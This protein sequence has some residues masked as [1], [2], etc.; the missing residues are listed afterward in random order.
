[1]PHSPTPYAFPP[2]NA[3]QWFASPPPNEENQSIPN[4][5]TESIIFTLDRR[6]SEAK[7]E[8]TMIDEYGRRNSTELSFFFKR[9]SLE[10]IFSNRKNSENFLLGFGDYVRRASFESSLKT[11]FDMLEE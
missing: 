2:G 10:N 5:D 1:L 3:S 11:S 6:N 8:K 4:F 7:I 9:N